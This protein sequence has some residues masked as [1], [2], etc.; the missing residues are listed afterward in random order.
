MDMNSGR[1]PDGLMR[2]LCGSE[3]KI[4]ELWR[5][6]GCEC[7]YDPAYTGC[8][9]CKI[10]NP[11]NASRSYSLEFFLTDPVSPKRRQIN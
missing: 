4:R 5:C 3:S 2:L 9:D 8:P 6:P 1:K 10:A 11:L 7:Y